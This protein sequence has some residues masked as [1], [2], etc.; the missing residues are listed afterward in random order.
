MG[1]AVQLPLISSPSAPPDDCAAMVRRIEAA[2]EA[3]YGRVAEI[4]RAKGWLDPGDFAHFRRGVAIHRELAAARAMRPGVSGARDWKRFTPCIS[5]V[6]RVA[7]RHAKPPTNPKPPPGIRRS[8]PTRR[9][10]RAP[11][12]WLC[13][14]G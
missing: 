2:W 6:K 8:T 7:L 13:L 14:H 5:E 1:S 10:R 4:K 12:R 3:R 9:G 11:A